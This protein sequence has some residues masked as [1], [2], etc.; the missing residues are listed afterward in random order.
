M[1]EVHANL[2]GLTGYE[3]TL[4]SL[5]LYLAGQAG[6]LIDDLLQRAPVP[7]YAEPE[8]VYRLKNCTAMR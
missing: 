3:Y 7:L 5:P 2:P 4:L 8:P 6:R 1:T